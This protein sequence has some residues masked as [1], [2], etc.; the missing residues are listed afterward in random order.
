MVGHN[1][2]LMTIRYNCSDNRHMMGVGD[3]YLMLQLLSANIF[4]MLLEVL[5]SVLLFFGL[6]FL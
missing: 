5:F 1:I 3:T 2:W 6:G 4:I